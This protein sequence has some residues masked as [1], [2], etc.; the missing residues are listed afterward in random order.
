MLVHLNNPTV[1]VNTTSRGEAHLPEGSFALCSF[2]QSDV[3]V[4]GLLHYN[5]PLIFNQ[6]VLKRAWSA[7][8]KY[9]KP[10]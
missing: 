10:P 5:K 6:F 3:S 1:I 7:G 9:H 8:H 4:D 2:F